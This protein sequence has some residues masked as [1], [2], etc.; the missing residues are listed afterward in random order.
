MSMNTGPS[1]FGP[2]SSLAQA[3]STNMS[4]FGMSSFGTTTSESIQPIQQ[5]SS[6]GSVGQSAFGFGVSAAPMF[7]VQPT[8]SLFGQA[9]AASDQ[10]A[11]VQPSSFSFAAANSRPVAFG[12]QQPAAPTTAMFSLGKRTNFDVANEDG[13]KRQAT[14]LCSGVNVELLYSVQ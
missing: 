5:S 9:T 10:Q 8:Q 6:V 7:S 1:V 11:T 13:S 12:T 14:G 3:D 4:S 2:S